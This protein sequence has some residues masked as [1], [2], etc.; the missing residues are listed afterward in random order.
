M[1]VPGRRPARIIALRDLEP[2]WQLREAGYGAPRRQ[3]LL[4]CP[5]RSGPQDTK[6]ELHMSVDL[7]R[8]DK[9]QVARLFDYAVLPKNTQEA[10]IRNGCAVTRQY[11]FAAF[12]SASSY[13]TPIAVE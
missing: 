2:A 4:S 6:E 10:D 9:S 12:Y 11:R 7:S 8:M 13:W 1:C 3:G 5:R